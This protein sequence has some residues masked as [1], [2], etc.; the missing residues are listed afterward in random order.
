M[1]APVFLTPNVQVVALSA[2]PAA[3]SAATD[4]HSAAALAQ[5][6]QPPRALQSTGSGIA[7]DPYKSPINPMNAAAGKSSANVHPKVQAHLEGLRALKDPLTKHA[8]LLSLR[9]TD[10]DAFYALTLANLQEILP[11]VYTPTVGEGC[12][13][14]DRI[15]QN[16]DVPGLYVPITD[17]GRVRQVL[18]QWKEDPDIIVVTDGSRI[19][20]LGDLG[21]NGMGIPIGKLSLYCAAGGFNPKRMLPVTLDSGTNN[22]LLRERSTYGGLRRP[23]A[24]DAEYLPFVAEFVE[25]VKA[26]WPKA[27]LQFEDFSS[28]HCFDLLEQHRHRGRIFN[29]DIQGTGAVIAAGFVNAAKV[30]GVP[31]AKQRIVFY[32]AGSAGQGVADTIKAVMKLT[33]ISEEDAKN[34][35]FFVDSKGLVTTNRGDVLADYKKAYARSDMKSLPTLKA[36]VDAIKPTALIG[37]SAVANAF[38]ED[39]VRTMARLNSRPIIFALSN[40]T[41]K[42][43]L[44]APQ[45]I[46]W[47]DG[48]VVYAAGSPYE[49]VT[50]N[51]KTYEIA[52]G[53]NLYI[54]PG[55]GLGAS[56]SQA[57]EVSDGMVVAAVQALAEAVPVDRL[58]QGYIFPPLEAI[59][60]VSAWVAAGVIQ[61]AR[62][63]G[64]ATTLG[65]WP[66]D[67]V[68]FVKQRMWTP[69]L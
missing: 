25:A 7:R 41:S 51:G 28:P 4:H 20:G 54:F 40:P 52:Q 58:Q 36:V 44:A 29:D 34:A 27:V 42:S 46:E 11:L 10:P 32:G 57:R 16:R 43:E 31:L 17:K 66:A 12:Q 64:L 22:V 62:R 65:A 24:G 23:R 60:D 35:F 50:H 59:R 33:G 1:P 18:D 19:L 2:V 38:T 45:A 68:G 26:K 14:F 9:E 13:K 53:N 6:L 67:L 61:Q 3:A 8:H 15:F 63:E 30:A 47:T 69:K 48:R 5:S 39:V 21:T 49:N 56:L 55:L 37:L